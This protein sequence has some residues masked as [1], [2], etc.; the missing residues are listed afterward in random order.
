MSTHDKIAAVV[1]FLV[2]VLLFAIAF[3]PELRSQISDFAVFVTVAAGLS[4]GGIYHIATACGRA[5][6]FSRQLRDASPIRRL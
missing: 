6:R 5:E 4:V 1:F 2:A 3:R